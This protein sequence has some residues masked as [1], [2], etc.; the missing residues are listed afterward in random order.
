MTELKLQW[1]AYEQLVPFA[2]IEKRI[3]FC[4]SFLSEDIRFLLPSIGLA[5]DG[6]VVVSAFLIT[7]TYLCE[8]RLNQNVHDF[9]V[10]LLST[11]ANYRVELGAVEIAHREPRP[12]GDQTAQV[13]VTKVTYDT[14]K[15]AFQHTISLSTQLTYV[16]EDRDAWVQQ[17]TRAIPLGILKKSLYA[18]RTAA[19][20]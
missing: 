12:P 1:Q 20:W 19:A 13:Q 6:R 8:V 5:R 2:T 9:D 4:R 17:V 10:A 7:D 14:A 11:I 16:G 3:D 15:I 18:P